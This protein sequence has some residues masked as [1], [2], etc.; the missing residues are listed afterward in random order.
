M[1]RTGYERMVVAA[2]TALSLTWAP[3]AGQEAPTTQATEIKV[4]QQLNKETFEKL[5]RTMAQLSQLL[6]KT[7][8]DSARALKQA[9]EA[10]QRAYISNDMDKVIDLLGKGLLI[11]AGEKE[12]DVIHN[13]QAVLEALRRSQ[14]T[15]D[16]LEQRI[17]DLKE[18]LDDVRKLKKDEN[19]L[20]RENQATSRPSAERAADLGRQ[21][22]ALAAEQKKLMDDTAAAE[23]DPNVRKLVA[24]RSEIRELMSEHGKLADGAKGM[25]IDK[26]PV[27][28]AVEGKLAAKTDAA[29]GK[30][31]SA[32]KDEGLSQA[33]AGAGADPNAV[34]KAGSGTADAAGEMRKAA[35]ALAQSEASKADKPQAA[36][37]GD[38]AKAD[39][40]LTALIDKMTPGS[41]AGD[42]AKRQSALENKTKDVAKA[43]GELSSSAGQQG[44]EGQ[45]GQPGQQGQQQ[46]QNN[47]Q[48]AS[49][50]MA[51]AAQQLGLQDPNNALPSQK[52]ALEHLE[53]FK[54]YELAQ[55]HREM[56]ENEPRPAKE[57]AKDQ[58][59]LEKK[60]GDLSQNMQKAGEKS[61]EGKPT[62]GQEN[63][64]N[65]KKDMGQA[66]GKMDQGQ[67]SEANPDQQK[68]VEELAKAEDDLQKAIDQAE[69]DKQD[70]Q[71]EK[72]EEKLVKIL[73]AQKGI[74]RE[75][76]TSDDKLLSAKDGDKTELRTVELK[77]TSDLS[78]GEGKLAGSAQEILDMLKKEGSTVVFPDVLAVVKKDLLD[79][80]KRLS[81]KDPGKLTQAIQT[82]VERNLNEMIDAL[83]KELADRREK[84][85]GGG[86]GGGGGGKAPLVPPLAE[87]KMLRMLQ[88]Q[89]NSRT[90]LVDLQSQEKAAP[91]DQLD[92]QKKELSERE[93][94]VRKLTEETADKLKEP[95]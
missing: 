30:V 19:A 87:L 78:P 73:D 81:E 44:Q 77:L 66:A 8:P 56:K 10:A 61:P 13:L 6:E 21:I 60:A 55:L 18:F 9:V 46:Q 84:K 59:D 16:K 62:P 23:G 3:A 48:K 74:S 80:Q 67:Q 86:G 69:K 37:A 85:K 64:Q 47:L 15:P 65:A 7:D 26:L 11:K 31:A 93:A 29:A 76:K 12:M 70:Q 68:S 4:K 39:E 58:Q 41:K 50:A 53:G 14:M 22:D 92:Q 57:Q 63:V 72:I 5:V 82:E 90:G 1:K 49:E 17:K 42:L 25:P 89:I 94:H 51:K 43:A 79:V 33:I 20:A 40:A 83:R 71:I 45:A 28:G 54:K 35:A 36:A 95:D 52:K 75:T 88:L 2:L 27:A 38:L 24:L 32:A 34:A 91:K